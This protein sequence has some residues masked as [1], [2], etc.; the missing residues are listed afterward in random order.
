MSYKITSWLDSEKLENISTSEYWN[1]K[2]VETKKMWSIPNDDFSAL[3][4]YFDK[5]QLFDQMEYVLK[6]N[7]IDLN[8]NTIASL[9][10]GTCVLES[11]ILSKYK[12][13]QKIFCVESF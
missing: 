2:E 7:S 13:I 10:C 11:K 4:E 3:E 9:A 8:N 5:K 1:N 12:E 6:Q